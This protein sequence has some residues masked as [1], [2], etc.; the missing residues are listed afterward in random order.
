MKLSIG[1]LNQRRIQKV[2]RTGKTNNRLAVDK[3]TLLLKEPNLPVKPVEQRMKL[4]VFILCC[5]RCF[6]FLINLFCKYSEL[7][8]NSPKIFFER[9]NF[10]VRQ[11]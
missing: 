2:G 6:L 10:V 8:F 11:D 7:Y 9:A 5:A 3:N 4:S 1:P